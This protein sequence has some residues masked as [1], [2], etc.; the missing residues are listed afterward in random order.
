MSESGE[1]F[2]TAHSQIFR[3]L[4]TFEQMRERVVIASPKIFPFVLNVYAENV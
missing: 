4:P 1:T 2:V 3:T